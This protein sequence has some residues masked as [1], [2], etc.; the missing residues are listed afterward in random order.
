MKI[1]E[2][3][4]E[5]KRVKYTQVRI[6]QPNPAFKNKHNGRKHTSQSVHWRL[7]HQRC[8]CN[9]ATQRPKMVETII[10]ITYATLQPAMDCDSLTFILWKSSIRSC[11]LSYRLTKVPE[12]AVVLVRLVLGEVLC[13]E[14]TTGLRHSRHNVRG[15]VTR[16][17]RCRNVSGVSGQWSTD[18]Q[19]VFVMSDMKLTI[20][21]IH[22]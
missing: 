6:Y 2:L 3:N 1:N 10:L 15:Q 9:S 18:S 19:Q 7:R 21:L 5:E 16:V 12:D 13:C 8:N 17:Q 14:D 11:K 20:F 4:S 22:T